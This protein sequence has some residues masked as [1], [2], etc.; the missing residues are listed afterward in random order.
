MK[1]QKKSPLSRWEILIALIWA[2]IIIT[3]LVHMHEFT[4]SGILEYTPSNMLLAAVV[5]LLFFA[6]KSVSIVL[7]S[8]ILYVVAGLL[9]PLPMAVLINILG[10]M[11]MVTIPYLIGRK[12]GSTSVNYIANK[13]PQAARLRSMQEKNDFIFILLMRLMGI[14]PGD[15]IS[16][17][18]G[19]VNMR[20]RKYLVGSL[21]GILPIALAETIM[22]TA[23]SN[24][25]SPA[26]K[27]SLCLRLAISAVS[28]A[29]NYIY[30]RKN[31]SS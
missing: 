30:Q 28:I 10:I 20:Y 12:T 15:I 18:M 19:A 3:A 14:L 24:I 22:G 16:L 31:S 29:V 8:G 21:F 13:Y 26:F 4:V 5:L 11:V 9:F 25:H 7:Y 6:L 2:V 23:I 1:T 27:I 17:Y